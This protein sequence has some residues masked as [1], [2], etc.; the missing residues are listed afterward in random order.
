MAIVEHINF[1]KLLILILVLA[2]FTFAL[3]ISLDPIPQPMEYHAF[4]DSRKFLGIPNAFDVISNLA[5]VVV[6]GGWLYWLRR[7]KSREG[8]HFQ[9]TSEYRI[10]QLFFLS[11]FFTGFGS[12][13][14][15]LEPNNATL[16]WDR[17]PLAVAMVTILAA[18][19]AERVHLKLGEWISIPLVIYAVVSVI[20]WDYSERQGS[21]DLRLYLLVQCLPLVL[22][23]L[24]LLMY[25]NRDRLI[26]YM[27]IA[28]V[29]LLGARFT[30]FYDK[31]IF[32]L[33]SETIS[34]H[35]LKHL[36]AALAVFYVGT[37]LVSHKKTKGY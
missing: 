22:I 18:V 4:A 25:P 24:I 11:V 37:Y 3:F 10:Y 1:K 19:I 23:P 26:K 20:Y 30:E 15:H 28:L 9:K 21:G 29:G 17:L 34:G 35:T 2:L 36:F 31:E 7:T 12:A 33:T 16:V 8:G 27:I 13:Y 14:Y 5:F 32:C 6:G